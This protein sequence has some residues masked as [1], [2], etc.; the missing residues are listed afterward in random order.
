M[1]SLK[2]VSTI[3]L[4]MLIALSLPGCTDP[5]VQPSAQPS[6]ASATI[7]A[8]APEIKPSPTAVPT[9]A[10]AE[11]SAN[12]EYR[13]VFEAVWNTI[14]QTYFDRD[15]GGLDWDAIGDEYEP[16]IIAAAN[17]QALYQL[18]N[19]MIWELN[20]SH[21][22]VW[23]ADQWPSI[24]PVVFKN[25]EI[26][27]DVRLLNDQAVITR[28]EAGSPAEEAGLRPG[29][30]IQQING[31]S[32]EQIIAGAEE[33]MSP[34]YND[35]GRKEI[36][37]RSLAGLIYGDP[38]T[39][40]I[41]AYLDDRYSVP[42]ATHVSPKAMAL[43]GEDGVHEACV[44]RIQRPRAV[45][46]GVELLPPFCLE[47]E[48]QRLPSGIAYI[49]FNTFH[50]DL[51]PDMVEAVAALQDAPGII[52]DLRGNPGGDPS[53]AEQMA[54]QFLRGQVLF[55][56]FRNRSGVVARSVTGQDVYAGQ[57]VILID[58]SSYS[59]SE[60]FA[61]G[62]QATGRAV[63]I[64]ERSPGGATG[65]RVAIL[66]NG[67]CLG[68]P[69]DQLLAPDG[70]V[71]EGYGVIPDIE[72][73]LDRAS[74]LSGLDLQLQAAIELIQGVN[75][76]IERVENGLIEVTTAGEPLW[77]FPRALVERM[78]LYGV[79]G[80][81]LAVIN[82]YRVQWAKGYGLLEAG[83][84]DAV[85]PDTLFH[86]GSIAKTLSAAAALTLVQRGQL[87]LDQNVNEKLVSW[88]VPESE[89]TQTE[90]VTLR[91]LLSHSAGLTDGFT[92]TEI[93]C[94]YS[95]EGEAPTV[96]IQQMLEASPV[97]GL[98]RPARVTQTPGRK[99][100]YANLGY[101]IVQLLVDDT[102]QVPFARLMQETVLDPLGMKSSTFEQPLPEVLRARA[103]TEHDAEGQ[104]FEGKRHHFPILASGGL[105]TTPSDLARFA[106]EIV[107][108]YLGQPEK[109]LS[110]DMARQM[111]TVQVPIRNGG[112][113]TA[114]GLG[115][116]LGGAGKTL[117]IQH[118]GGTWGSTCFL[119]AYPETGQGAVVM[120]NS[121]TSGSLITEI[122]ISIAVEYGWPLVPET[123][124]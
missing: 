13:E 112:L 6:G 111:L 32:V 5:G 66:P 41:L 3:A 54:A 83:G 53:V 73:A 22:G 18:L 39:C 79:P 68:C 76:R 1:K 44:E 27:I 21:A 59:A 75:A 120:T 45:S 117:N 88:Q 26:G 90:K 55:G 2:R 12:T 43:G 56:S 52:I 48:S 19:Q 81:S 74:L 8:V 94:C 65:M 71:L 33:H 42:P 10:P 92:E 24:E 17:D 101:G 31:T 99:Y 61:S 57:L 93:E 106:I 109:L 114:S 60:W 34:P 84:K 37:T 46:M 115:F 28:V 23:P 64:G 104:P 98:P 9:M 38:G 89:Y 7:T 122:L 110:Q 105:W 103:S 97:T 67:G 86:A 30:I 63:I 119:I 82:D 70:R 25:G 85:T 78:E 121:R 87:D 116:E 95:T 51:L 107:S 80:V 36:A 113:A 20:V 35:Q 102:T 29:F 16:L 49:R 91:R 108:A 15:F 50:P 62:M 123:A 58:A 124:P 47:F 72:V 4:I 14:D 69:V 100:R 96:S 77:D 11:V 40:V 118:G